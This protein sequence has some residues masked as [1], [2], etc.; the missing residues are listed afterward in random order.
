MSDAHTHP[1]QS[2]ESHSAAN[3]SES[4]R[5]W[6]LFDT[7]SGVHITNDRADLQQFVMLPESAPEVRTGGGP[8][9]PTAIGT[10]TLS[11]DFEGQ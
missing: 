2:D 5:D 4:R 1:R 9:R 3:H 6:W 10:A 7:G 8:V 11:L